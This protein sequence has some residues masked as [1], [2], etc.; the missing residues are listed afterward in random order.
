MTQ[1]SSV[2]VTLRAGGDY[3]VTGRG[4]RDTALALAPQ[5]SVQRVGVSG[6][7]AAEIHALGLFR[8]WSRFLVGAIDESVVEV[9][10]VSSEG[11]LIPRA[12]KRAR[13]QWRVAVIEVHGWKSKQSLH[14]V[15]HVY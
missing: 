12:G 2:V 14:G 15:N 10:C 1:S 5:D 6:V 11:R 7:G 8:P 3:G 13:H 4:H 9:A